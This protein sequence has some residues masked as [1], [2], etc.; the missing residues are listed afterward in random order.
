MSA[1]VIIL[2]CIIAVLVL[3]GINSRIQSKRFRKTMIERAERDREAREGI[4]RVKRVGSK[5]RKRKTHGNDE[6]IKKY[7]NKVRAIENA[8]NYVVALISEGVLETPEDMKRAREEGISVAE[9]RIA[10]G[11]PLLK[12]LTAEQRKKK[13]EQEALR[14]ERKRKVELAKKAY[15]AGKIKDYCDH[16]GAVNPHRCADCN[17]CSVCWEVSMGELCYIC[18][19]ER[20]DD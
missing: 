1:G 13:E 3:N 4:Y 8:S 7:N 10:D 19:C 20:Y 15:E 18:Y 6:L 9:K 5:D 17:K 11:L 14:T 2:L 12:Y 16:C